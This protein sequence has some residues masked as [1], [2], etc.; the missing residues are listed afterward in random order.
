MKIKINQGID[1][2]ESEILMIS[3]TYINDFKE[4]I[5]YG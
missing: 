1:C 4:K 5:K 2:K 3:R